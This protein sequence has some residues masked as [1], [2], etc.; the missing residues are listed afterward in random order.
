[1]REKYSEDFKLEAIS[2]ALFSNQSYSATARDLGVNCNT[3]YGWI[4][5][6][7]GELRIANPTS[8]R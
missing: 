6:S 3:F 1:M 7:I 8:N 4:G 5:K 2:L